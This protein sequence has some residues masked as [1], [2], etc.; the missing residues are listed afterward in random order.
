[1][2]IKSFFIDNNVHV[3]SFL[4]NENINQILIAIHGFTGN[5]DSNTIS[6]LGEYFANK[7]VLVLS[8]D[9]PN[10]GV[11]KC[12]TPIVLEECLKCIEIVDDYVKENYKNIPISYFASSYGA[13]LLLNFLNNTNYNYNKI[14]IKCP[15]I[16]ISDI[17]VTKILPENNH[18]LEELKKSPLCFDGI[19]LNYKFYNDL[20]E[21]MLDNNYV[22]NRHLYVIQGSDDELIDIN[23]N[24]LFF[25]NKCTAKYTMFYLNGAGHSFKRKE[26]NDKMLSIVDKFLLQ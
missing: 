11:N 10:H 15:A 22:S 19:W 23:K 9:L 17:L 18:D 16:Y 2:E 7:N 24:E 21:N 12:D 1:M 20:L 4:C 25:K 13:Y 5:C 6:L 8:F 14:F 26:H 3:K